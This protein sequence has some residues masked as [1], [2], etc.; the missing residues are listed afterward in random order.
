MKAVETDEQ[1]C[2]TIRE[3]IEQQ[4]QELE[5][6]RKKAEASA[7]EHEDLRRRGGCQGGRAGRQVGGL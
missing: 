4:K 1:E 6:K 3:Q 5:Q 7:T 2:V